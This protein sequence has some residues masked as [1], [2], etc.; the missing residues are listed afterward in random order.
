MKVALIIERMD[1][2]RGGR[3]TSTAQIATG[4]AGRGCDVTILCQQGPWEHEGVTIRPLGCKGLTRRTKL[5]NFVAVVA[6]KLAGGEFDIAHGM[7]PIPGINVY[8]P[9]GGTIPAQRLASLRRRDLIGRALSTVGEQFNGRRRDIAL[10]ERRVVLNSDAACLAVSD[11]IAQEFA[12]FYGRTHDVHT[13]FNGVTLPEIA[14]DD[15]AHWRQEVRYRL[16][17]KADDPV[18]ITAATN[19][20]LKG[21][22]ELLLA[23]SHWA[24]TSGHGRRSKLIV[25][26]RDEPEGYRRMAGLRGMGGQVSFEPWTDD[27]L[28]LYA[29]AD[30]VILLSWYDPC[31]RVV[32]E[33]TRLGIPSVTTAF[34]G[35]GEILGSGAGIVVASPRDKRAIIDAME[36]LADPA[37]RAERVAACGQVADRLS[38]D[39]HVDELLAVYETVAART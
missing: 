5:K 30:A 15:W 13:I 17:A 6:E 22:R 32:L 4:L 39:R 35:A 18:F 19:F 14:P 20:P 23:Y 31:S 37:R 7:L 21:V 27:L 26:G 1:L 25:V 28:K 38:M 3:E 9:R 34:N 8:Q 2:A 10:L 36:D 11:M 16:G 24:Q 33:A 29:A 12:D